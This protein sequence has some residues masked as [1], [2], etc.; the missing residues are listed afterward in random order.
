MK[1][2]TVALRVDRPIP[3]VLVWGASLSYQ[4]RQKV[5]SGAIG[6]LGASEYFAAQRVLSALSEAVV[7]ELHSNLQLKPHE[8][9]A[10][11]NSLWMHG[12]NNRGD[13]PLEMVC[14]EIM[15]RIDAET[16]HANFVLSSNFGTIR[17]AIRVFGSADQFIV[18]EGSDGEQFFWAVDDQ[19]PEKQEA[20][21]TEKQL[22]LFV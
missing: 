22:G 9:E 4:G 12:F 19:R 1:V 6:N 17:A 21:P 18:F 3:H 10:L 2:V 16:N 14:D 20:L 13:L 8:L 11:T 5:L 15:R 7:I